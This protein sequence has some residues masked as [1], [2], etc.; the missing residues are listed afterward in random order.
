[1][2]V[3]PREIVCHGFGLYGSCDSGEF[4]TTSL[5]ITLRRFVPNTVKKKIS[6]ITGRFDSWLITCAM[7][8]GICTCFVERVQGSESIPSHNKNTAGEMMS[9]NP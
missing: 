7:R 6:L 1:M 4:F 2:V 8:T 5:G 9:G 3:R